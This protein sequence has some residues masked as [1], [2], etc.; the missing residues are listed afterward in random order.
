[1]KQT[2]RKTMEIKILMRTFLPKTLQDL[3]SEDYLIPLPLRLQVIK[4]SLSQKNDYTL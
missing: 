1:M 3:P 4:T 2:K